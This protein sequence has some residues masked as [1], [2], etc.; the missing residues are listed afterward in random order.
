MRAGY[1]VNFVNDEYLVALTGNANT[2]AGLSRPS[3][4]P[5]P[6]PA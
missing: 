6:S 4:I 1:S 2:N 5:P 3:P